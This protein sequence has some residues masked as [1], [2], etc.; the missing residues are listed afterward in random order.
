MELGWRRRSRWLSRTL[1]TAVEVSALG[2]SRAEDL[3]LRVELALLGTR[4]GLCLTKTGTLG[5][6]RIA[7]RSPPPGCWWPKRFAASSTSKDKGTDGWPGG[8]FLPEPP[9]WFSRRTQLDILANIRVPNLGKHIGRHRQLSGAWLSSKTKRNI[10]WAT[11]QG[12][13]GSRGGP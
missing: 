1:P 7:D 2:N 8:P 6:G 13:F 12:V 3:K 4:A 10:S 11:K 9:R 5:V